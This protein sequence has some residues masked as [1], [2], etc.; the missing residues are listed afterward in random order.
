MFAISLMQREFYCLLIKVS[1]GRIGTAVAQRA[2]AFGFNIIF[3][4][5]YLADG[6]GRALGFTRV[7]T[8]QVHHL[9]ALNEFQ[10]FVIQILKILIFSKRFK[11]HL[12]IAQCKT[13][14]CK[15]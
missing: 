13:S 4:D 15:P 5:P 12:R 1:V 9:I 11:L 3:Y 7:P 14:D 10:K 6:I 2:K 8:L